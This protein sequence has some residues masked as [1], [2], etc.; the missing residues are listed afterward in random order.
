MV[1][2]I[3]SIAAACIDKHAVL[4][5]AVSVQIAALIEHRGVIPVGIWFST[6]DVA[7]GCLHLSQLLVHRNA[8]DS[9]SGFDVIKHRISSIILN[10]VLEDGSIVCSTIDAS[11]DLHFTIDHAVR[12]VA[13]LQTAFGLA[14][15]T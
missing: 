2:D 14:C 3:A 12:F 11:M 5:R 8:P 10:I 7:S 1:P 15:L 9:A 6:V 13:L 4:S